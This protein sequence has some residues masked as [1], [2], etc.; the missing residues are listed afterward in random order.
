MSY[1]INGAERQLYM[2]NSTEEVLAENI[3]MFEYFAKLGEVSQG[4]QC[5]SSDGHGAF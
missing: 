1:F 3:T 2:R 5:L 4:F